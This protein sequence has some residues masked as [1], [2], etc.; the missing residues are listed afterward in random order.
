MQVD[1][2]MAMDFFMREARERGLED[3]V[4]QFKSLYIGF[5]PGPFVEEW[6]K[7]RDEIVDGWPL[8]LAAGKPE[9]YPGPLSTDRHWSALR[10]VFI[11]EGW[12]A[13]RLESVDASSSKVVAHTPQ[14]GSSSFRSRGLV[15]GYVQS[16]KTT[17]FTAVA[18]KMVDVDYK[19]ILVLSGIHNGL[20]RQTQERLEQQLTQ[21]NK[22]THWMKLTDLERDFHKPTQSHS[23]LFG[24]KNQVV[25]AA[26]KK[27]AAVLRRLLRWLDTQTGKQALRNA[28]VL[29]IDDEADQASVATSSINPLIT[30][31]LD[32]M[33]KHTYIGYT[34]TPFANV[35]IDPSD[36]QN[37]YPRDFILNLP[38]PDGYFGPEEVFGKDS[39]A[40]DDTATDGH[41]MVRRIPDG[42]VQLLRPGYKDSAE[43]FEPTITKDVEAALRWFW[44]A[45]AAR[46]AR[47]QTDKH[48]TMLI[49]T[50]VKTAVHASYEDPLKREVKAHAKLLRKG[51]PG[52]LR[53]MKDQW[54]SECARV[55]A[56]DW[57]RTQNTFS[58]ILEFLPAVLDDCQVFIDNSQSESRIDYSGDPVV[59]VAVGGNTLSRGLTLEGL[60]VSLFVRG[61]RQYDTLLQMGRWFGFRTGYEDL[62]RI[63][64]TEEL[65]LAFR[66]LSQVEMEMRQDIDRYQHEDKTPTEVAVRIR[67]HPLLQIT[68]KMGAA[69]PAEI[70]YAGSRLQTRYFHRLDSSLLLDNLEA[71]GRLVA[72]ASNHAKL[73]HIG[74][75]GHAVFEGVPAADVKRFL[76]DYAFHPKHAELD[77]KML[78]AYIDEEIVGGSLDLWNIVLI[79]GPSSNHTVDLGPVPVH[80]STRSRV[81]WT[82]GNDEKER[83]RIL[84]DAAEAE[85]ADIKTL[86]S[87]R[88]IGYD[89]VEDAEALN[90]RTELQL[91]DMRREHPTARDRGLLVLYV[92][93]K[94]SEPTEARRKSRVS[95]NATRDILGVGLV[96]P[97]TRRGRRKVQRTHMAV[98][99]TNVES[100]NEAEY[101]DDQD[102]DD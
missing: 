42:D 46:R 95:L 60:V 86:M 27:N 76:S 53:E 58:E 30:R 47:G 44:M 11:D 36:D 40:D 19:F 100:V 70:S 4:K 32:L 50:S 37:L 5:D 63:W 87:R 89:L 45:T 14:P 94:V 23:A 74:K 43:D 9:W 77:G 78:N 75:A 71:G 82:T 80:T 54:E 88:D 59:A 2:S 13:E 10:Q 64:I 66:H 1:P 33:P 97:G 83:T 85:T 99:L 73:R 3:T 8:I 38:K 79:Q 41:D 68:Q 72:A 6:N 55:D 24:N 39:F 56:A 101:R 98:D 35:F 81:A 26:V 17:N 49:H 15:V 29:V 21:G 22:S 12:D 61:A 62:P 16:G 52:L 91:V 57:G 67:T 28:P 90:G 69:A 65:E 31:I 48:S 96:F 7:A 34:A 92:I 20:R 51:D 93:D 84:Q 18:A 102:E 25:L